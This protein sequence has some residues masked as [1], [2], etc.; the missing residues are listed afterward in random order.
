M[1]STG[2]LDESF[3]K[4]VGERCLECGGCAYV[5]PTCY[6]FNVV[7]V[8]GPGEAGFDEPGEGF[9]PAAPGGITAAA[10]DGTWQ[11]A[12]LRDC[13]MLPGYVR[14]AGGGYPRWTCGERCL[15]RFFHKL[16]AQFQER[17][18]RLGC[19]GCGRCIQV[20]LGEE[21]IDRIAEGMRDALTGRG[22]G[23]PSAPL[24]GARAELKT[25]G[26]AELKTA[27]VGEG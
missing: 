3:W 23:S 8:T 2:R 4:I 17:M 10:R 15:T 22:R 13:C 19:T 12:R 7:D 24:Q 27:G 16:S 14:Q 9:M 18:E 6:C 20:C 21:G 25:A 26:V 5:C 1:V 11:R